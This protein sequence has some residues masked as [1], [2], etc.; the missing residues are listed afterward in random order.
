[1]T[2]F[3]KKRTQETYLNKF[4]VFSKIADC[5]SLIPRSY[6]RSKMVIESNFPPWTGTIVDVK[7]PTHVG[8]MKSNSCGLPPLPPPKKNI[9][10][11]IMY[12]SNRSFN[13]PPPPPRHLNFWKISVQIPPSPSQI[14][15]QMPPPRGNKPFYF[16]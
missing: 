9:D 13:I 11:C 5:S 16:I 4:W 2:S 12:Q 8:F 14:A 1:M 6:P 10:R 3:T 7:I 15:A